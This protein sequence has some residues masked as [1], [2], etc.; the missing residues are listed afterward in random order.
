[1]IASLVPAPV[2]QANIFSGP[3]LLIVLVIVLLLFGGK[4]LPEVARSMGQAMRAFKDEANKLQ[5]DVSLDETKPAQAA[6]S[7]TP[8]RSQQA[9]IDVTP[10]AKG[11]KAQ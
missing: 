9:P 2:I 7:A 6:A 1:M 3:E 5:R 8:P 4:K 11:E 10:E